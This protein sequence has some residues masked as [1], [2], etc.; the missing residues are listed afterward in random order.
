MGPTQQHIVITGGASG[1]G[2]AL[3]QHLLERNDIS[4]IARPSPGLDLLRDGYPQIAVYEAD[5][6]DIGSVE[7]AADLLVKSKRQIDILINNA[8]VQHTPKFIDDDFRYATIRWEIDV[9]FTSACTLIYLLMP[10]LWQSGSA[11][12]LN[13]NSGLGLVPKTSSAIYC[14]TKGALNI[15]TRALRNQ[16]DG[17]PINVRQVFLPL[18]DTAMTQGRGTGKMPVD[19]AASTIVRQLG[20]HRRDIYVG[21]ARLL[22][23]VNRLAPGVA[24]RLMKAA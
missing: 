17:T 7:A 21:K 23:V 11:Q 24:A 12:V 1:L 6:A 22:R 4:V 10:M 15:L 8:A 16:F 3:L 5:L 2:L 19:Q 18:V 20:A 9:N 14:A 13:I